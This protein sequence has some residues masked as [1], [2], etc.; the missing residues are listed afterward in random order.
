MDEQINNCEARM[1]NLV[2][3]GCSLAQA[4]LKTFA[5]QDLQ[6]KQPVISRILNRFSIKGAEIDGDYYFVDG[7]RL[8]IDPAVESMLATKS[9]PGRPI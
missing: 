4:F 7:S 8:S 2:D 6:D 9:K 5:H 1:K 3:E